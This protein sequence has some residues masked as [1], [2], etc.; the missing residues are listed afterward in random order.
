[1][2][3]DK[4]K[5]IVV[6]IY[7]GVFNVFLSIIKIL[8]G[9]YGNSMAL[10]TDGIHSFSDLASD[11]VVILGI[12]FG[13]KP[14]DAT[15]NYGHKKIETFSELIIGLILLIVGIFFAYNS[16]LSICHNNKLRPRLIAAIVAFISIIIKEHLY[17]ITKKV[18]NQENCEVL[19]ANAWHHRTDSFSSIPVL[20]GILIIYFFPGLY[21]LD[22]YISLIL[23]FIIIK[24][25]IKINYTAFQKLID[26]A[27]D[28]EI[29]NKIIE[30]IKGFE[31]IIDFHNIRMRYIGNKIFID[32][33]ILVNRE[34]NVND[35]HNISTELKNKIIN[36]ILDIYDVLIHIEPYE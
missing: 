23:S 28:I 9:I 27:P 15:H 24:V 31:K 18:G 14:V 32:L 34:L 10:V 4:N 16:I 25:G 2:K 20:A 8:S 35:A 3:S 29:Q 13:D 36:S 21:F 11:I 19:I 7:G 17:R 33:H 5:K 1:M 12:K 30:I 26:A 22:Y 6:T